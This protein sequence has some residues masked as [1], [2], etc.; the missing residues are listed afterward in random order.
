MKRLH[1][2][3][4]F[5]FI[6]AAC[7]LF[8][9]SISIYAAGAEGLKPVVLQLKWSHQ[10]Q[11]AGYYMAKELG[12]Y[13]DEG[14]DVEIRAGGPT[15][16]VTEEVVSG[17]ADFGVGTSSLLLDYAESKPVVV[18]GVIYQH[19]PIVL[20]MSNDKPSDT[21]EKISNSKVM[22]EAHSGDL[23][24]MMRR[25]GLTIDDL[26]IT[27]RPND[28]LSQLE[29]SDETVAIS[30]YQ[31]DEPYT[32]LK[33]GVSFSTFT[34]QTYG[35]D[36]YGDNFFT[37]K[38]LVEEDRETAM[39]FRR[40]SLRGWE[41]AMKNPEKAVDLILKHY[42]AI[43]NREKLMYE[44]RVT[45][46]LMTNLVKP[47][48]MNQERW[49]HVKNTYIEVGMLNKDLDMDGFIFV[50]DEDFLPEW[51]WTALMITGAIITMLS[52]LVI[53]F[54][55]LNVRLKEEIKLRSDV[56]QHLT[57]VNCDLIV[58]KQE[59]EEA[60]QH[61]TWFITNVSHDLK[62]PISS[63]VSLTQIFNHHSEKLELP[64]KFNRFLKQLNSGG[65]FLMLMLD[66]ILDHSA[67]EMN[68]ISIN[69]ERVNL[70]ECCRS[71]INLLQPLADE[72]DVELKLLWSG[73]SNN[74]AIDRTRLS[75]I[76]LN[77]LHN[78]IKFSPKNGI[79][80]L[81][82]E[83]EGSKLGAK[84]SDEGPGIPAHREKDLF[85][86]FGQSDKKGT[87]RSSTGLGLSIVKRNVDLLDGEIIMNRTRF[88]GTQFIILIPMIED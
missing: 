61:K 3:R 42:P 2:L 20:I 82:I 81:E 54:R 23:I 86:M 36:F 34:P 5:K 75:Q 30:A 40:A 76:F 49:N 15:L 53:Y 72:K 41:E 14:F 83:I 79:V 55:R 28:A 65:E 56:E 46:D 22:L 62:A 87:K 1:Q 31:T 52:I 25:A 66:N 51:F 45:Q 9:T 13:K 88:G 10:F 60:N 85:S 67:F 50:E 73:K 77:L 43:N 19:S 24:A 7:L 74:F 69:P 68:A 80:T 4:I 12:Y 38:S 18:L 70:E 16:D 27:E 47:G 71:V 78:A 21:I 6:L 35:I 33:K 58:A 32:L 8:A 37:S 44:A 29:Y 63:M 39:G 64:D 26:N 84:I 17:R 11:F 59:S 57:V 48:H